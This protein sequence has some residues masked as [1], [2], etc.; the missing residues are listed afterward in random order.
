MRPS[1]VSRPPVAS[2][3]GL[4]STC[5]ARTSP[6]SSLS[7]RFRCRPFPISLDSFAMSTAHSL[8]SST[9]RRRLLFRQTTASVL[10]ELLTWSFLLGFA[11]DAICSCSISRLHDPET[12][13]EP[14]ANSSKVNRRDRHPPYRA[15]A[16]NMI[17]PPVPGLYRSL[18]LTLEMEIEIE[19]DIVGSPIPS[20]VIPPTP[21]W[22]HPVPTVY[23]G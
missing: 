12:I 1:P 22:S 11:H 21:L 6:T 10:P 4:S 17:S 13:S 20:S 5:S 16:P 2:L 19:T 18:E 15:R 8:L 3:D 23:L 14:S 7:A 9:S